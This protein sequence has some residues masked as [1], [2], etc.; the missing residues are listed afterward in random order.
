MPPM[1]FMGSADRSARCFRCDDS[2]PDFCPV[3]A[4][5]E[6]YAGAIVCLA[7]G[8]LPFYAVLPKMRGTPNKKSD[9][10]WLLAD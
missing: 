4:G 3:D 1:P 8:R 5:L 10:V 6:N 7:G 2:L 9:N